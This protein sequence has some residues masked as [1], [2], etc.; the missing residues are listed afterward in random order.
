MPMLPVISL[1]S[2]ERMSPNIFSVTMTSNCAGFLQICM[3]QLSTNI[4]LYSTSGYSVCRRC[5]TAR[6]RRLVSSTLALSTQVSFLRR[7]IAVSKPMRQCAR[8]RARVGHRVDGDLLAVL[9]M[10]LC[11]PE[12]DAADQ[13]THNDEVNAL[14]NDRLFQRGRRP[15]AAAR[16]WPGGCWRRYHACPRAGAAALL[17]ALV[18]GQPSHFCTA[19]GTEQD[20]VRALHFSSSDAGAG[21]RTCRWPRRPC[22]RG[23][24]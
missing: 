6:H 5:M 20:A 18:A 23:C 7:F 13:L 2:S 16:S 11:S 19:D 4:S 24:R 22:R 3:A 14:V 8:S 21:R 12:V 9:P 10:V 17:G 1:A 15:P